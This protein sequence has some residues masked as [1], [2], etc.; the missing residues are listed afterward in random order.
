LLVWGSLHQNQNA[1]ATPIWD[2]RSQ[3]EVRLHA[4][5]RRN[6]IPATNINQREIAMSYDPQ[7]GRQ[8]CTWTSQKIVNEIDR[9]AAARRLSRAQFLDW[10]YRDYVASNQA[11]LEELEA[12]N[13]RWDDSAA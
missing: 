8:L 3:D 6:T 12:E 4:A 10:L 2:F 1:G 13:A 5:A 9:H 11:R 7:R